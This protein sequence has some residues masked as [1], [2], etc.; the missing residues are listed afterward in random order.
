[1]KKFIVL[2]LATFLAALCLAYTDHE[3]TSVGELF[4]PGMLFVAGLYAML[5]AAVIAV[6]GAVR[7]KKAGV[8]GILALL[9]AGMAWAFTNTE[10][11]Y[12][13]GIVVYTCI[14]FALLAGVF[15]VTD[16]VSRVSERRSI[17]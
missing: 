1:M 10:N 17:P 12:L 9:S 2:L 13:L 14:F 7:L 11:N 6:L 3:T 4:E 5:F 15:F 8:Y 16:T